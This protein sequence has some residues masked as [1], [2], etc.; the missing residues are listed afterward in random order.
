[1]EKMVDDFPSFDSC[2][3]ISDISNHRSFH[4]S[5]PFATSALRWNI[6]ADLSGIGADVQQ[7]NEYM[8]KYTHRG[9]CVVRFVESALSCA[10]AEERRRI[11]LFF[12]RARLSSSSTRGATQ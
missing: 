3:Y 1:V 6:R 8:N 7:L 4:V 2:V 10:E 12:V 11:Y 9:L 5:L